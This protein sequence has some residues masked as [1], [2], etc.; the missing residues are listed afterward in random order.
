VKAHNFNSDISA[1]EDL[2][3]NTAEG[4]LKKRWV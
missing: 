2:I 4:R 1:E 3:L